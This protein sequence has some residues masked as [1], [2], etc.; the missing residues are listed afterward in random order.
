MNGT[1]SWKGLC[2]TSIRTAFDS[3]SLGGGKTEI[4]PTLSESGAPERRKKLL[5]QTS[6]VL[7]VGLLQGKRDGGPDARMLQTQTIPT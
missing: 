4:A 1:L 2:R 3:R 7:K 5:N 6:P